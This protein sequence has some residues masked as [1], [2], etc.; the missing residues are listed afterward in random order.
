LFFQRQEREQQILASILPPQTTGPEFLLWNVRKVLSESNESTI[1][2]FVG[3]FS[4]FLTECGT[5]KNKFQ[6]ILTAKNNEDSLLMDD[7]HLLKI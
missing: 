7:T 3:G 5:K 4:S 6:T 2:N 1:L